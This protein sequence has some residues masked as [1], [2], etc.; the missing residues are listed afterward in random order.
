[1]LILTPPHA[2]G[3]PTWMQE[4]ILKSTIT[5]IEFRSLFLRYKHGMISRDFKYGFS[6]FVISFGFPDRSKNVTE[7]ILLNS[8]VSK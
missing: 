4:S 3:P 7:T 6:L 2:D 1:M 8:S 5:L